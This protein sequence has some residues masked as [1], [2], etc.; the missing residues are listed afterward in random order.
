MQNFLANTIGEMPG[1]RVLAQVHEWQHR[2]GVFGFVYRERRC[3]LLVGRFQNFPEAAIDDGSGYSDQSSQNQVIGCR[4]SDIGSDV[5]ASAVGTHDA[6]RGNVKEPAEDQ[7][8]GKA[9]Y[10]SRNQV[11]HCSVRDAPGGEHDVSNLHDQQERRPSLKED[12]F[13]SIDLYYVAPASS[14]GREP[15]D[16]RFRVHGRLCVCAAL[17]PA[18]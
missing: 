11:T 10:C 15:D 7:G 16:L 17:H 5:T 13:E 2:N 4:E 14:D 18:R 6:R 3:R 9:K 8:D 1:I 12:S